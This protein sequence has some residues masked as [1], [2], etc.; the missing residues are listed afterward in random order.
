MPNNYLS[1]LYKHI[2]QVEIKNVELKVCECGGGGGHKHTISPPHQKGVHMPPCPSP[3][4]YASVYNTCLWIN[5]T[6]RLEYSK[7]RNIELVPLA[8]KVMHVNG[9]TVVMCCKYLSN[10]SFIFNCSIL[11]SEYLF[12][13]NVN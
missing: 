3:A 10:A 1:V 9:M 2:V 8:I 5:Q 11:F 7:N 6:S 12:H 4:S 13:S